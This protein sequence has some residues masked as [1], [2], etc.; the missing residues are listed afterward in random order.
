[1]DRTP[2]TFL[3]VYSGRLKI[4]NA[5]AAKLYSEINITIN[6]IENYSEILDTKAEDLTTKSEKLAT[7]GSVGIGQSPKEIKYPILEYQDTETHNGRLYLKNSREYHGKFHIHF[8]DGSAMTGAIHSPGSELLYYKFTLRGKF[9]DKLIP[10]TT[11]EAQKL[12]RKE[13]GKMR[14]KGSI[15]RFIRSIFKSRDR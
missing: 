14:S 6:R 4:L 11:M 8:K 10:T 5:K 12:L 13:K 9:I 1:M 7:R 2:L 15:K 3:F